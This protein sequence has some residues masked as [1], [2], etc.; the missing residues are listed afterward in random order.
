M[1]SKCGNQTVEPGSVRRCSRGKELGKWRSNQGTF[2]SDKQERRSTGFAL[3][4][5]KKSASDGCIEFE[6]NRKDRVGLDHGKRGK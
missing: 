1:S 6:M 5:I 4:E 2:R 3:F